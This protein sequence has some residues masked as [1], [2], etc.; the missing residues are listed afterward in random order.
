MSDYVLRRSEEAD[1]EAVWQIINDG[2][3]AYRG[4]IPGDR[5]KTPYMP[6][7]ELRHEMANGVEFWGYESGGEL[8]GVMG[9]QAVKDVTLIR[10]AYVRSDQQKRGIGAAL[11]TQLLAQTERPVLI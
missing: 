7:E 1:F 5:L 8:L 4:V 6:K 10:H 2:A 9:S 11:L 3:E